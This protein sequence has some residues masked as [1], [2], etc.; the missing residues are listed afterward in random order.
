MTDQAYSELMAHVRQTE[1]LAQVEGLLSW[2]QETVMPRKATAQRA[3]QRAA[4]ES[5]LH[6]RR[7]DPAVG[8]RLAAIDPGTLD[9]A[10]RRNIDLI[11]RDYDRATR[12]PADLANELAR[13]TSL[14]QD[15]WAKARADKSF[16]DFAPTLEKIV[17]LKRE[18]A[19]CLSSDSSPYEALLEDYEPGFPL[20]ELSDL[21]AKTRSGLVDIRGA[22]EGSETT[23]A[24]L[25]GSFP[26]DAQRNLAEELADVFAYDLE[27]GRID[28]AIH[29]FSSG[30]FSDVRITTRIDP[31]D[32]LNCLYSTMHEMGHAVYEQ[33]ID[34]DNALTPVGAFA[35]MGVH[36]SQSRLFENQIG[37]SR[38]FCE[39]LYPRMAAHFEDMNVASPQDLYR[40]INRVGQG[41]IRTE[42]DEVHYNLHVMLRFDLERDLI[43]GDLQVSDLEGAWNDRFRADFGRDVP[44]ASLG[45]LQ[46]VHWSVGLFGY[47]PTYSLGNI[48]AGAIFTR[49]CEVFPDLET[50][51]A[52]GQ[53]ARPIGWL[54]ENIHKP[55]RLHS[56]EDLIELAT[57]QAVSETPLLR[58]LQAKYGDLY[59][60]KIG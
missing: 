56:G 55:G 13:L 9:A 27:A 54:N 14:A 12:I 19:T 34:H 60:V 17:G 2:D 44:D 3:E 22:I 40:A 49:L 45:V 23:I 38:A 24:P 30:S 50:D 46:D 51:I 5:V 10:E 47:F 15:I 59:N 41:F 20:G 21:L 43:N 8:E 18:E 25:T 52:R 35:S 33:N 26:K 1:A 53:L 29:P 32:P 7:G 42:A 31:N 39:W 6:A 4:L 57:G 16:A 11:R 58:Y 37:R 36:E 28:L 48:F